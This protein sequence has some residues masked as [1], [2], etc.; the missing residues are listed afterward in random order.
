[1]NL[2]TGKGGIAT[3]QGCKFNMPGR[4]KTRAGEGTFR[5]GEGTVRTGQDF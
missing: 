3:S 4:G 2:L 5:T 1:M